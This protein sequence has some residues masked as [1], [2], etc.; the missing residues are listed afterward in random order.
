VRK[1]DETENM[2][3]HFN[4]E[5]LLFPRLRDFLAYIFVGKEVYRRTDGIPSVHTVQQDSTSQV[6]A[7]TRGDL[8]R[9]FTVK[10]NVWPDSILVAPLTRS[11]LDHPPLRG[12]NFKI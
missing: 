7:K 10:G 8:S 3:L 11:R 2:F 6:Y 12:N 9:F 5:T 4:H 1:S